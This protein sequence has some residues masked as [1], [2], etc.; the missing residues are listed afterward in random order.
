MNALLI[1]PHF[2]DTFWSFRHALRFVRKRAM[3]PPLGL[4]TVA[5][6]LPAAWQKRL[7]DL[8]V[9]PLTAADLEWADCVLLSGMAVQ[10]ESMREVIGRCKAAGLPIIAGGPFASASPELLSDVDHLV[11][12]EAELTL[13]AFLRDWERGEAKERY[14]SQEFADLTQ[15]PTPAW[16]LAQL[17]HYASGAIQYSRGCP[18]DC[19]FC[20]VTSLFGHKPRLKTPE[21]IIAEL[22]TLRRLGWHGPIFFVDDNLIGNKRALRTELLPA[23]IEW[24]RGKRGFRFQTQVSIDLADD[25]EFLAM[26]VKAGF[27]TVFVGI[28]TPA[29]EGL[30]ECNKRQNRNRDLVADVRTMH[31]AGLQVQGGFIVGFD[32][33]QASIFERQIEFIQKSGIV[34]AM[35]GLLQAMPGTKL[36]SRLTREGRIIGES[37][38]DNVDGTT[39]ILTRMNPGK[40]RDGYQSI[41]DSI[42]S[43]EQYY[44]RVKTFLRD[45]RPRSLRPRLSWTAF[46]AFL[47]ST[48][49]LGV[50]G[51]GRLQYWKLMLWTCT[52]RPKLVSHA[53]TLLIVG[54]H[55]RRVAEM[56]VI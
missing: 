22:E 14:E 26:F 37:T 49:R 42:Y 45:Y 50:L 9:G 38:G 53:V 10:Q 55:F 20:N 19:E 8:N 52:H 6:M 16:E 11:L 34:A 44:Q 46:E 15:S 7:V 54:H 5:A 12:N 24:Q 43:P 41:L 31:Q 40:L 23:L 36:Y 28:E 35:V 33:D 51:R 30:A 2:P 29:E 3:V 25:P 18:F 17:K 4:L 32:S 56:H 47:R 39:N 1:Q 27:S 48:V 21:Q 13:P